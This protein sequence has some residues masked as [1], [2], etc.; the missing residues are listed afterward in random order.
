LLVSSFGVGQ[1]AAAPGQ[2]V[3]VVP[4][5]NESK[6]PGLEWIG[7]SFPELL[8]ERL[9]SPSL[10]VLPREDRLRAYDR[11]GI[12][13]ELRP[14][15][16]TIYRIAEQ[17]DVDYI[18]LGQYNF[19][20]RAFSVNAQLLDMRRT[21]LLPEMK[22]TGPL[23]Q[24]IDVQTGLAWDI[25]HGIFPSAAANRDA[26]L[27]QAVPVRLDAFEHYIKGV[28]ASAPEE[29]IQN[30]HEAVR[31]NPS[32][33]VATLQL[34]KAYYRERQYEQATTWLAKIPESDPLSSEAN[35]FLGLS[36]YYHGDLSKAESAFFEVADR[37]PLA[38]V[39]NDLG[40][41]TDHRDKKAAIDCF[42]K[43][44]AADP[45][46]PDYHFNLAVEFY[47]SG[48]TTGA[49]RQL[50]ETL[51]LRP[52]D[53]E[54]KSLLTMITSQPHGVVP[55][56]LKSP[57]ERIR[58]NYEESTFRQLTLKI[59]AVAEQRLAK[60][61]PQTHARYHSDRGHQLLKQGFLL[62]AE[63]EF[64]EALTLNPSNGD[65]HSGLATVLESA[66]KYVDAR[67]EAESALRLRPSSEALLVL[68]KLDLRENKPEMANEEVDRALRMDPTNATAQGLKQ[69][70]AAKLAQ[71]AQPLPNQ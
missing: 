6:A 71:E 46:E 10:F 31:L 59:D 70:V 19:D 11:L 22:E 8:K 2:T 54:A 12:P 38:G 3:L 21:H 53:I 29:Q 61:D 52:D 18:V 20:G 67:N 64:R 16:P 24:L 50:R 35:F 57:A 65:A 28:I 14:S 30:F 55:A 33:W 63:R 27:R 48:D 47:R 37:L 32:Y 69:T 40:V 9:D 1:T 41:V 56:S 4:F 66:N 39:Y 49:A 45:T 43:A 51:A 68:A 7:D 60:A 17:L 15:R 44:A 13:I 23:P 26:Y 5:E 36:A 58:S 62:E 42:Q 34:G 25:L